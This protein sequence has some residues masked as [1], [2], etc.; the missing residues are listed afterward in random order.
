LEKAL[1]LRQAHRHNAAKIVRTFSA[2]EEETTMRK[3]G[4]GVAAMLAVV[5]MMLAGCATGK[6]KPATPVK[7]TTP[8][9][10]FV[11]RVNAGATEPYTDK[12]GNVWKPEKTYTKGGGYGFVGDEANR[13]DR[14]ADVKIEGTNDP[15]IYQ[16]ERWL[17]EQF[18]AEVSNGK[19]T[20]RL[21]FAE[22][23]ADIATAG[24]RVFDVTIQGNA[25]L[26]DFD[27]SKVAG[28]VQKAVVKEFKAV[29]V[30]DGVLKIGFVPKQQN[31]EINGIEIL[32]E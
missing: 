3:W 18:V 28:G 20:V 6:T 25:V 24:P 19:Y 8:A 12:A 13:I 1:T 29:G 26:K 5:S 9:A 22:T 27:V 2:K 7:A 30:T 23:Y 17:M 15:R 31:A 16:T 14:G 21:H 10:K 4:C 32:S 11:L